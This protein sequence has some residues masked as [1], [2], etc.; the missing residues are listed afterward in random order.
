MSPRKKASKEPERKRRVHLT[1]DM[2]RKAAREAARD[3]VA[4][5]ALRYNISPA[6]VHRL[7]RDAIRLP[8]DSA[9]NAKSDEALLVILRL[10]RDG[11]LA[12][13]AAVPVVR[14]LGNK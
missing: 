7:R 8:D 6:T 2:K 11:S 1:A 14:Q 12:P 3:G 9:D 13:D 4:A 10:V 5:V